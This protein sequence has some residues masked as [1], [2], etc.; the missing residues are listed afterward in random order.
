MKD[1]NGHASF[2]LTRL[3][4]ALCLFVFLIWGLGDALTSIYMIEQQGLMQ[5]GNAIVRLVITYYGASG[6]IMLKV[7]FT[8][9][10][11]C[12]PFLVQRHEESYWMINGYLASFIVGGTLAIILNIQ[13]AINEPL[14]ILPQHVILIYISSILI[15]TNIGEVIDRMT[16]PNIGGFLDCALNDI[17]ILLTFINPTEQKQHPEHTQTGS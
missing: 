10:V 4:G 13:A 1:N 16:H 2:W 8:L 11:I 12:V 3:Q 5:E 6:F 7:W 9:L 15:L 17:R 14:L